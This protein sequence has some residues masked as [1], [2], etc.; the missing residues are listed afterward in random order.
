MG[1][2]EVFIQFTQGLCDADGN[3][4]N[5]GP[6]IFLQGYVDKYAAW[7]AKVESGF[8]ASASGSS[9]SD[10]VL[11]RSLAALQGADAD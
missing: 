9:P 5:D 4:T 10:Y 8:A 2:P 11:R 7:V 6:R 1:Q 3:V